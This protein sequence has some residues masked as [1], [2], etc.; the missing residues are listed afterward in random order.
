MMRLVSGTAGI[1]VSLCS[2]LSGSLELARS[3]LLLLLLSDDLVLLLLVVVVVMVVV[4]VVV[5]VTVV[6]MV[7]VVIVL[8]YHSH[9]LVIQYLPDICRP[10]SVC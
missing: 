5:M 3:L 9:F 10:L 6:L 4:V 2:A 1:T 7:M 8:V